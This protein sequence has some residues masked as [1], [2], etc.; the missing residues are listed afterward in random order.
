MNTENQPILTF[1]KWTKTH[2]NLPIRLRHHV[3]SD[4]FGTKPATTGTLAQ[5]P[6]ALV[7]GL[8]DI[9]DE[10]TCIRQ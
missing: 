4:T 10:Q 5:I 2:E 1:Y 9:K 8:I 6:E 3:I 7:N